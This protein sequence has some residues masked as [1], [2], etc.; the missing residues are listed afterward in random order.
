MRTRVGSFDSIAAM[1]TQGVGIGVMPAAVA[2]RIARNRLLSR[3]PIRETWA[4]RQFLLCHLR[5]PA[6]SSAARSVAAMLL[7][8]PNA[9]AG[10]ANERSASPPPGP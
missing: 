7:D 1:V 2:G 9:K 4:E 8:S 3:I 5:A 10:S 6:W